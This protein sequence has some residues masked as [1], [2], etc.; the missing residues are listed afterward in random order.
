MVSLYRSPAYNAGSSIFDLHL[1]DVA[2][3]KGVDTTQRVNNI[4]NGSGCCNECVLVYGDLREERE[5]IRSTRND[6]SSGKCMSDL[7]NNLNHP[8]SETSNAL[9][10]TDPF[11][12]CLEESNRNND[13]L[14]AQISGLYGGVDEMFHIQSNSDASGLIPDIVWTSGRQGNDF[15]IPR[16]LTD[17]DLVNNELMSVCEQDHTSVGFS[18]RNVVAQTPSECGPK[19]AWSDTNAQKLKVEKW[20]NAE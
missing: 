11:N 16:D 20:L 2:E 14:F 18:Q 6:D 1:K 7:Q 10:Y 12:L 19:F 8:L 17:R 15:N 9:R 5:T 13:A 3:V 4:G